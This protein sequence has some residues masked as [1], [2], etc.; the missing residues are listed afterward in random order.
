VLAGGIAYR[1]FFWLLPVALILGGALGFASAGTTE[2]V[3]RHAGLTAAAAQ[4]VAQGV[5]DEGKGRWALLLV[6]AGGIIWTSSWSVVALQRVFALIWNVPPPRASNPLRH[7]LAFSA[8]LGFAVSIPAATAWLRDISTITG[9][10]AAL[11]SLGLFFALWLG[12][13]LFLPHGDAPL[14]ALIPG[15]VVM[16]VGAQ[17]LQLVTVFYLAARLDRASAVYGSLGI[18]A[19]FLFV[20]WLAG[21][22]VISSAIFNVELWRRNAPEGF[23]IT[24]VNVDE[25]DVRAFDP[26]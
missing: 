3:S 9:A 21:R 11:I 17:V 10:I 12:V 1:L 2:A 19:T 4:A 6:G 5:G 7:A 25:G 16:A 22:L 23:P 26:A 15:A 8:V 20:L 13:S 18:A 14:R 24:R